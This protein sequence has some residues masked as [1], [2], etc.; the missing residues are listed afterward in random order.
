MIQFTQTQ[1]DEFDKLC[2]KA[3]TPLFDAMKEV[4]S[5][6]SE[7]PVL[8]LYLFNSDN[9]CTNQNNFSTAWV[10][11]DLITIEVEKYYLLLFAGMYISLDP[12]SNEIAFTAKDDY[13][14]A[15]QKQFTQYEIDDLQ[16]RPEFSNRVALNNCKIEVSVDDKNNPVTP[17]NHETDGSNE[18]FDEDKSE[19]VPPDEP[20][21]VAVDNVTADSAEVN[22]D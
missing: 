6:E 21:N 20:E 15:Y 5:H 7:Y 8:Y 19:P 16:D 17:D 22:S 9:N 14:K 13:E 18:D 1:K 3:E 12:D 10:N 11:P 4:R 2:E